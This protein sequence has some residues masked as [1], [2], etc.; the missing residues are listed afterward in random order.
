MFEDLE[1]ASLKLA[2][3]SDEKTHLTDY[4]LEEL[5]KRGH[6]VKIYGPLAGIPLGWPNVGEKIGLE[7]GSARAEQGIVFCWTGTESASP[8]T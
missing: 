6:T 8:P 2:V 7:V 5:G 4:V 1:Q 3:G